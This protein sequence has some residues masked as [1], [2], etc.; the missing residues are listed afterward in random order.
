MFVLS[1]VFGNC[2]Q[3]MILETF[4]D[5]FEEELSIPDLIWLTDMPKTTIY[6]YISKLLDE[7]ILLKGNKVGKTQFYRL[8]SEKQEVK[9]VLSLLNYIVTEKLAEKLEERGLKQLEEYKVDVANADIKSSFQHL[10]MVGKSYSTKILDL[11]II[12]DY[13]ETKRITPQK[14]NRNVN[15]EVCI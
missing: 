8:N 5:H 3:V 15:R 7:K 4:A 13:N 1:K 6:S 12:P 2:P 11:L 14:Y 9:I 10:I